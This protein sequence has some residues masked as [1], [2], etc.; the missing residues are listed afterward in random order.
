MYQIISFNLTIKTE[1]NQVPQCV[2]NLLLG[3]VKITCQH[4]EFWQVQ[5]N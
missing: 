2:R 3:K 5:N 4:L 1:T